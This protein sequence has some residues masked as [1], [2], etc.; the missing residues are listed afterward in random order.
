MAEPGMRQEVWGKWRGRGGRLRLE[1]FK[2]AAF[3]HPDEKP[4]GADLDG[5]GF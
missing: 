4:L 3:F 2:K 1:P 5:V